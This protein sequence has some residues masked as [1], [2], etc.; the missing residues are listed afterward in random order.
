MTVLKNL[1]DPG[2][3]SGWNRPAIVELWHTLITIRDIIRTFTIIFVV[4]VA[5]GYDLL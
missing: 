3:A 1:Y 5:V 2:T 4:I